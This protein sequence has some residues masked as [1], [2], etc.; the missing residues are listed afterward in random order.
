M[1]P[2]RKRTTPTKTNNQIKNK[3]GRFTLDRI[4]L[5]ELTT[6]GVLLSTGSGDVGQLGLGPDVLEKSRPA[7]VETKHEIV[8]I[9]AGGMHS[10][11]LTKEGK[12]LTFG[13]NDEGTL[14][15]VTED[16][17]DS[18][19]PGEVV[20]PGK[21]IQISAGDSHS[22]AL[23]EDG[24]VFAWGTFR[25][26]HGSMGLSVNGS[27]RLPI[28]M[29]KDKKIVK[30][31][32]GGDHLVFLTNTGEVWTCGCA[33]QGQLGRTTRRRSDREELRNSGNGDVCINFINPAPIHLKPS[34][35]LHFDN[36]W[37]STYGT[38]AKVANRDDIY[39]CGVN[40][41]NQI[42]LDQVE[43][44]Y[45]PKK[46]QDFSQYKWQHITGGMHHTLGLTLD[47][48]VYAIGRKEYGR[49]G[50]GENCEDAT[51]LTKIKDLSGK[52]VVN[53]ACGSTTSFA[54][55]KEGELYGWGMGSN[56]QLGLGT[57]DDAVVP[58]VIESKQLKDKRVIRVSSGG[59]HTLI[60]CTTTGI[61]GH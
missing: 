56:G 31:A 60:L 24:R 32:S 30:I 16:D 4:E 52:G 26:S 1:A 22:A 10:V 3:R 27:E 6:E 55:T 57:D 40:N 9:Y 11:C 34:P 15:R 5:P 53:V 59:Q 42:G 58:T 21:V 44:R 54:V 49:L 33:E 18:C 29:M 23:L 41:F 47:K 48:K 12:V 25:D 39:V 17:D 51:V 28:E 19:V 20:L 7:L 2:K 50:L 45:L 46:S 35:K 38:F 36:I 61:N 8:D 14:G 43:P 37:A 13:C